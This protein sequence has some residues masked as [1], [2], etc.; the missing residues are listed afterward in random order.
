[1]FRALK[2]WWAHYRWRKSGRR[3]SDAN[4]WEHCC[5]EWYNTERVKFKEKYE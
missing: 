2:L 3:L 1:M 4:C 5:R